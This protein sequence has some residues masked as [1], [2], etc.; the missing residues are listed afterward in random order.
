MGSVL[1]RRV[2]NAPEAENVL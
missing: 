2:V 1:Q